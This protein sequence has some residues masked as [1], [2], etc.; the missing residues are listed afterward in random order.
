MQVRLA[1]GSA[2]GARAWS[3]SGPFEAT[4]MDKGKENEV[5]ETLGGRAVAGVK[6]EGFAFTFPARSM[7]AI[8]I[9]R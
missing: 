1:D 2:K 5:R 9:A 4:N 8:D 3:V 7:T 6:P